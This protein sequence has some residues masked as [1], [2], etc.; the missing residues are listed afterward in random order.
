M[1]ALRFWI[2]L[3]QVL[4]GSRAALAAENMTLRQQLAVYHRSAKRP[5]LRPRDRIFWVWL[6]R[7]WSGWRSALMIVQPETVVGW[8]RQGFCLYWRWK[9]RSGKPG[10]PCIDC[11]LQSLIRRISPENPLW[12]APRIQAEIRLLGHE[13]AELTVARY[14][15]RMR[16][17]A[18]PSWRAFLENHA[19]EI[20]AIN[21]LT[22]PT[23]IFRILYVFVVLAHD[24]RRVLYFN[25]TANPSA[26]WTVN[27]SSRRS[28]ST[29]RRATCNLIG[30]ALAATSFAAASRTL[31]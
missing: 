13:F 4:V 28:R 20:P 25:V 7:L 6:A 23:A 9:S 18:S 14:I 19:K 10:R 12:G 22:V 2:G 3:W 30:M 24:R 5:K 27:K 11:R 15:V 21:F 17:P 8:R 16:K 29:R 31:V 1:E 26:Q